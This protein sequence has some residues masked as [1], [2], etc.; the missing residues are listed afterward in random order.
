MTKTKSVSMPVIPNELW[1]LWVPHLKQWVVAT[2]EVG[3]GRLCFMT[4]A[5]ADE[6][7]NDHEFQ[8]GVTCIAVRVK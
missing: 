8:Y 3:Y 1:M 4:K 2:D 7:A 6:S 5:G